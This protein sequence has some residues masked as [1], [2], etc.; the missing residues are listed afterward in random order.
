MNDLESQIYKIIDSELDHLSKE[1][2]TGI[3]FLIDSP[4][5]QEALKI[6]WTA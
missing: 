2:N 4:E 6:I 5:G 3:D 1:S